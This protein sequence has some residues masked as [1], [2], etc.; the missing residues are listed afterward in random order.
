MLRNGLAP[1]HLLILAV[2]VIAVFGSKKLPDTARALGKSMRILKSEA[3][4]MKDE[5]AP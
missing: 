5:N 3:R 2:I 1:W 4:A